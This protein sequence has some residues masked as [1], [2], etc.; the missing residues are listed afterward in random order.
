MA[1]SGMEL[2][3][4]KTG[5]PAAPDPAVGSTTK[6]GCASP[7]S[8]RRP[9]TSGEGPSSDGLRSSGRIYDLT[10]SGLI[11]DASKGAQ[12]LLTPWGALPMR[13]PLIFPGYGTGSITSA[14]KDNPALS[15][16]AVSAA[17]AAAAEAAASERPLLLELCARSSPILALKRLDSG[18]HFQVS[19]DGVYISYIYLMSNASNMTRSPHMRTRRCMIWSLGMHKL[20]CA[21]NN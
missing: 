19:R 5:G 6:G 16:A 18:A 21:N 9:A 10:H 14:L 1:Y 12:R 2:L 15:V 4:G 17:A 3:P 7:L 8:A 20:I 13:C 11:I